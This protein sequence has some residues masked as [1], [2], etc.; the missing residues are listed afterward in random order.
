MSLNSLGENLWS[1][2]YTTHSSGVVFS[3]RTFIIRLNED[4]VVISPGPWEDE[5]RDELAALG[6]VKWLIAP[7]AFHHI[8]FRPWQKQYPDA[9][10][11]GTKALQEKRPKVQFSHIWE[12]ECP[13]RGLDL[14]IYGLEGIPKINELVF[15]HQPTGSLIVTDLIFNVRS[16]A[17]GMSKFFFYIFGIY[18]RVGTSL[19]FRLFT[20]DRS[21]LKKSLEPLLDLPIQRVM[22]NHGEFIESDAKPTLEAALAWTNKA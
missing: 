9:Q 12:G 20:S 4:L 8:S 13:F 2:D 6:Q 10:H 14:R 19:L 18:N 7:N 11:W 22:M 1:M 5:Y 16:Y 21:A 3:C 15:F 17:S